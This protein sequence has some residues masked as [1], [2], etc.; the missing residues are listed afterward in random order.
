VTPVRSSEIPHSFVV[1]CLLAHADLDWVAALF[2][3]AAW[4]EVIAA[5][6]SPVRGRAQ[7]WE[8][9]HSRALGHEA[10]EE[11]PGSVHQVAENAAGVLVAEVRVRGARMGRYCDR[12]GLGG[13]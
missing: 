3:E 12:F 13:G 2:S 4:A 7:C 1:P 10:F 8:R 11:G 5:L 6:D 9:S